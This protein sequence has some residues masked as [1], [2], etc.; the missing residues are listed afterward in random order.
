MCKTAAGTEEVTVDQI[1]NYYGFINHRLNSKKQTFSNKLNIVAAGVN[2]KV[3]DVHTMHS[4]LE[5]RDAVSTVRELKVNLCFPE[6]CSD[7]IDTRVRNKT[8]CRGR[9]QTE[10]LVKEKGV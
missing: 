9:K 5:Y 7:C 1:L 10:Q 4:A 8:T 2:N 3:G 6:I